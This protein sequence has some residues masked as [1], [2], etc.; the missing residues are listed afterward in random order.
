VDKELGE[1]IESGVRAQRD[2]KDPKA[3][4]QSNP[5]RTGMQAKA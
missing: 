3:A 1:K 5:A 4:E 2:Q